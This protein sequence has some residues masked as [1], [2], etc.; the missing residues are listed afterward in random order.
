[1]KN[2]KK[3]VVRIKKR[4]NVFTS[5]PDIVYAVCEQINKPERMNASSAILLV[6]G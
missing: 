5:V 1:L 6:I 2:N 4:Q 3:T